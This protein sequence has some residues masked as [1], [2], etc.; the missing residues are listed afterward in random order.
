MW[1][2]LQQTNDDPYAWFCVQNKVKNMNVKVFSLMSWV[3]ET[4]FLGQHQSSECK[5]SLNKSVCNSKPK[6]N[7]DEC[8]CECKEL[9][10]WG[11]CKNY[12]IWNPS[13]CDCKC[14]KAC[15]ID[16]Y[17]DIKNCSYEKRLIGKLV[18]ECEDEISATIE[19]L[20][21]DKKVA[22][23]ESNSLIYTIPL[24]I[25]CLLLLVVASIC[26]YYYYTTNWIRKEH[27]VSY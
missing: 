8:R 10:D 24:V 21:N 22:Y 6:S 7:H 20:L 25:I 16:E 15:R 19:T 18:L 11:F 5:C 2:K 1:W 13:T 23:A 9:N 17:L 14:H 4:R 3:N 12:C 27:V 26:R